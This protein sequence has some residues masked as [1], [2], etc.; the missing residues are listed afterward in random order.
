MA[1]VSGTKQDVQSVLQEAFVL[2]KASAVPK[3]IVEQDIT[4]LWDLVQKTKYHVQ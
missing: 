4:V 2:M 3:G 1:R